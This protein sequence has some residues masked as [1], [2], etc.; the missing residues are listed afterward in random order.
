MDKS[1]VRAYFQPPSSFGPGCLFAVGIV[2]SLGILSSEYWFIGLLGLAACVFVFVI[3]LNQQKRITDREIDEYCLEKIRNIKN[4][5]IKKIGIDED[6]VNLIEPI[7]IHGPYFRE[8]QTAFLYK[9][10]KDNI[11]RSSNYKASVL[12]FSDDQIFL[13]SVA[14]SIIADE[15]KVDTIEYFYKD[16][17]S[18][19]T[20]DETQKVKLPGSSEITVRFNEFKLTTSGGTSMTNSI[21]S[22]DNETEKAIHGMRQLIRQKKHS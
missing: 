12:Y 6:E 2:I 20:S 9:R 5:A 21:I 19:T 14:F 11:D 13:Y 15:R 4:E 22:L 3:Y 10:G 16:I 1:K 7:L 8:I 18:V 17:V